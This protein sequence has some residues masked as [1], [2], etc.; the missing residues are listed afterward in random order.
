MRRWLGAGE[1]QEVWNASDGL[2][3][4]LRAERPWAERHSRMVCYLLVLRSAAAMR[5]GMLSLAQ[6]DAEEAVCVKRA[7]DDLRARAYLVLAQIYNRRGLLPLAV[8]GVEKAIAL[9]GSE[10]GRCRALLLKGQ[11][12][13]EKGAAEALSVSQEALTLARKLND[14]NLVVRCYGGLGNVHLNRGRLDRA[15]W[16][17]ERGTSFLPASQEARAA[18]AFCHALLAHVSLK[19]GHRILADAHARDA[20]KLATQDPVAIFEARHTLWLLAGSPID[21]NYRRLK[22]IFPLVEDQHH[23]PGI[24]EFEARLAAD[25]KRERV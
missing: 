3:A 11:V 14:L 5:L 18:R 22:R 19:M 23:L 2:L 24:A 8:D 6:R 25:A 4:E 9:A 16:Y 15:R 17:Y 20:L 1:Y 13:G 12:L 21:D 10:D 7:S